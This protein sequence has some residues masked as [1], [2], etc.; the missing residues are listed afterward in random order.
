ML[1]INFK[2]NERLKL[3][4]STIRDFLKDR[5]EYAN[6]KGMNEIFPFIKRA[7]INHAM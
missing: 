1:Q 2:Q 5:I 3:T 4:V 7:V 6:I